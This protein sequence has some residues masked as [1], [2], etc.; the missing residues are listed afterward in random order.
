MP[1][2]LDKTS[3]ILELISFFLVTLDLLGRKRIKVLHN[4]FEKS[5]SVAKSTDLQAIA[6][7]NPLFAKQKE[8]GFFGGCL[9]V[10]ISIVSMSMSFGVVGYILY[11][12][13]TF[14]GVEFF[15]CLIFPLTVLSETITV[16]QLDIKSHR[17][18]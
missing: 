11:R 8:P 9:L 13:A 5:I 4:Q 6:A 18:G 17:V 15:L 16:R 12:F 10:P 1:G 7:R 14:T 3:I 2:N